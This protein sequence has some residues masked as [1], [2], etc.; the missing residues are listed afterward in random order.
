METVD[1]PRPAF[2]VTSL[3]VTGCTPSEMFQK[4]A[5]CS[6]GSISFDYSIT[7]SNQARDV[8]VFTNVDGFAEGDVLQT[9]TGQ[10]TTPGNLSQTFSGAQFD[11]LTGPLE[12]RV[13]LH[14][15]QFNTSSG[16]RYSI[17]DNVVLDGAVSAIPEPSTAGLLLT[18]LLLGLMRRR[19]SL[20]H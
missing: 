17:M 12:V 18:G 19:R 2:R 15:A 13:Y 9:F 5:N 10:G 7:I 16:T 8:S 1:T 20:S 14:D 11:G 4:P 6:S 3:M